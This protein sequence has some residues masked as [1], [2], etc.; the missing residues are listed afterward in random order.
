MANW[1]K[2]TSRGRVEDRRGMSGT[3]VGAI[4]ITGVLLLMGI[5]YLFGGNPLDVLSQVDITQLQ[6]QTDDSAANAE[7]DGADDYE[8]F[9]MAV[10]G[11]NNDVWRTQF[12]TLGR[13]YTEPNL[14]LF[15]NRT[16]SACGSAVSAIGPHY[17]PTDKTIYLDETFFEDLTS[18]FGAKGGDVAE[19]YVI[20]HEVGHHVQNLLGT[21]NGNTSNQESVQLELQADCF[22]GLWAYTLRD[23]GVFEPGEI[24]EA[25]DAAAAV[26]DDR[27]Q[28][29][30][31]GEVNRESWTHGSSKERE[32]AFARGYES[33]NLASCDS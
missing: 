14:V 2:I 32:D 17:C 18:R 25:M 16:N 7:F 31:E 23:E 12:A 22:A 21:L 30:T 9:V 1:N 29:M 6:T 8:V 24:T 28:N 4:S 15:R 20:G 13:T 27:I 3:G 5:N 26:G 11:S 19:A 33:G 10:L